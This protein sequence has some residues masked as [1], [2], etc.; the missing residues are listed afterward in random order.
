MCVFWIRTRRISSEPNRTDVQST[1]TQSGF[2][3]TFRS[4]MR[5]CTARCAPLTYP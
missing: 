1:D 5:V 4:V 2:K 3:A